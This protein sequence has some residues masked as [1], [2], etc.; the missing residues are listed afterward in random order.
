M[1]LF[2][3]RAK[4]AFF[5]RAKRHFR[6]YKRGKKPFFIRQKGTKT[7]RIK[8]EKGKNAFNKAQIHSFL[9]RL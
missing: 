5:K 2:K 6:R 1:F 9:Q 8:D 3:I 4:K 7:Q